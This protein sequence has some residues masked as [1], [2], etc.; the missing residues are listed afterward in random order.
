MAGSFVVTGGGRGVGG[1]I[2]R[3]LLERGDAVIVI[4]TG[5]RMRG[6]PSIGS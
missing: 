1:A 2:S 6:G 4:D 5:G 3:R